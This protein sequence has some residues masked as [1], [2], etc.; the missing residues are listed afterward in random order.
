[1][2]YQW[3]K[4]YLTDRQ[5]YVE[6]NGCSSHRYKL[7][8][9]VPQG[10]VL[11]PVLFLLFINDITHSSDILRFTMFADDTSLILCI[12]RDVY[13]TTLKIELSK[14][15]KWF[16]DNLL[17]L[18]YDK[19]DYLFCGPYFRKN[20]DTGE[21]DLTELHQCVPMYIIQHKTLPL[22]LIHI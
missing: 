16:E 17:L 3:F 11:G 12:D 7:D 4:S 19:T 13:H 22:S 14:V 6:V 9:G 21:N 15:M 20:M 2:I 5:Q 10:S 1:M 18:N 8:Y